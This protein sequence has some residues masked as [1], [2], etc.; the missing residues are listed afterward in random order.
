MEDNIPQEVKDLAEERQQARKS[1]DFK[2]ADEI[3]DILKEK[4][5]VVE[6]SPQGPKISAL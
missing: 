5:F 1:K 6:D 3:R 2:R 4:G